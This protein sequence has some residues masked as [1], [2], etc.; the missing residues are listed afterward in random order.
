MAQRREVQLETVADLSAR[1]HSLD[2][3]FS[4]QPRSARAELAR[5]AAIAADFS[6]QAA[7]LAETECRPV[8]FTEPE[9]RRP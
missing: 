8:V 7:I 2:V 6:R 5:R 3:L 9:H 4:P 1:R